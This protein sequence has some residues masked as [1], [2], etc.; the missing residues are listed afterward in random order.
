MADLRQQV[1]SRWTAEHVYQVRFRED[2]LL[3][4]P[5]TD[6]ARAAE[7]QKRLAEAKPYDEFLAGWL[8]R[9]PP[10]DALIVYGNWPDPSVVSGVREG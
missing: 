2:G 4:P 10:D 8:G 9:R 6:A 3:D 7:R 5:A 1:I